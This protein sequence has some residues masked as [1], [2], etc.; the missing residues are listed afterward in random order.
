M[1]FRGKRPFPRY[2]VLL[3]F[4]VLLHLKVFAQT[5]DIK[6]LIRTEKGEP[7]PGATVILTRNA[8]SFSKVTRTDSIGLFRF[9]KVPADTGYVIKASYI[10]YTTHVSERYSVKANDQ[11]SV[12]FRMQENNGQLSDVVVIGYGSRSRSEMVGAV[13][14]VKKEDFNVGVYSDPVQMLQGKVAGLNISRSGNPNEN[15][16]V[17]L[18][19]PSSFRSGTDAYE[20]FYVIDG[21]PGA[22]IY[23]VAPGDIESME[24]LKDAVSTSIYG[25]RAANGVII[26]TTRK[27]R[28]GQSHLS[29]S[30]YGAVERIS[31]TIKMANASQLRAYLATNNVAIDAINDDGVSNT[32]WQK[33]VTRTGFSHNHNLAYSGSNQNSSYGVSVNYLN[34]EGIIKGSSMNRFVV[35]TNLQHRA[36]NDRLKLDM[37]VTNSITNGKQIPGQVLSN[38]LTYMPTVPVKNAD[39]SYYEDRSRTTGT[40]GYY[41][42][43]ALINDNTIQSKANILLVNGIATVNI[44]KGLDFTTSVSY[45]RQRN[46]TDL[47]YNSS[48]MLAQDYTGYAQRTNVSNTKKVLESFATYERRFDK[49]NIKLLGGYSWQEDRNG[50]GYQVSGYNFVSDDLKWN[51]LGQGNGTTVN[52]GDIY[53][54]TLRL[55][56]FYGRA[57]Y[58]YNGRFLFQGSLRRDGSSAFGTNNRWGYFPSVSV[59]WNLH[60]ERFMKNVNFV[61]VLKVRAGYGV[62]GNST[63]FNAYTSRLIYGSGSSYFYYNGEWIN[64]L[65]PVQNDNPDL[66]W[67]RTA[68]M[69]VGVD[70]VLFNNKLS[71]SV[72]VYD[73]RTTDLIGDYTVSTTQYPYSTMTANVGAMSNKGI[74]LALSTTPVKTGKFSWTSAV[75]LAHNVNKITSISNDL[76]SAS[77]FYTAGFSARGQS[78]INGYQIIKEG[79]PLGSFY[80]LKY[81]GKNADGKSTFV[82]A[83]GTVS[84]DSTAFTNFQVTGSAQPKLIYGWNNTFRYGQFD[85]NIFVR[86]VYGNQ[87][88]NATRADMNAP[89]Y[90]NTTN[91]PVSTLSESIKDDKDHFIS[92]RYV[93]SGAYLRMDNATLGYSFATKKNYQ[94]RVYASGNNLFIITKYKGIDPEINVAG[95][96]PG[97][98]NRSYYPKTRTFLLGLNVTF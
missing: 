77:Q 62:V 12:A 30:T 2:A 67:E 6:G 39:G 40:S 15:A 45:Q 42:P 83:D 88:L 3:L 48:S 55:I 80:T 46:D 27:F 72:D 26:I 82:A 97:I 49:H 58:D 41:N 24:V 20:P 75:T 14:T 65:T 10:G 54:S 89:I 93:E 79:M 31:N 44:L 85:L 92:S 50:D 13:T 56:S 1:T 37:N 21:V 36:F 86:G 33:E 87:I 28:S 38:M 57:F 52:Y 94:L 71:G 59:G 69:N 63:G 91:V 68:T 7:L 96:T 84:S 47:Y 43:V 17:I 60:N 98:D 9:S 34:N 73:K 23:S 61:N 35:R 95:Q 81:A 70:F 11:L 22:S 51:N 16:A 32:D 8:S 5:G 19:G 4:A 76:F 18:R 25:S 78:G 64:S 53:V 66:K 90:A 74:E 29:Y